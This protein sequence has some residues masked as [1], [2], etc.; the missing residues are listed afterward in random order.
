MPFERD[1]D[2]RRP[3]FLYGQV[4]ER[5]WDD[6]YVTA[7]KS[8]Q[9]SSSSGLN[10]SLAKTDSLME[11]AES[12]ASRIRATAAGRASSAPAEEGTEV[13]RPCTVPAGA[14]R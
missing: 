11:T 9:A 8:R 13:V 1:Q 7:Y 3:T 14:Y 4:R 6:D 10:Q 12:L 2:Q 5:K